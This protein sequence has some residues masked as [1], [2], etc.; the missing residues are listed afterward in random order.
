MPP[1]SFPPLVGDLPYLDAAPVR[2][3]NCGPV[4]SLFV[5]EWELDDV[6]L[7]FVA[8]RCARCLEPVAR[9]TSR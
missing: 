7:P 1:P 6:S 8:A 9:L 3:C 4:R 2:C 5:A